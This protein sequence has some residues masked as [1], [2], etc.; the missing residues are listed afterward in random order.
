MC[1]VFVCGQDERVVSRQPAPGSCPYCGGMIQAVD[2]DSNWN[3]C[4]LPLY[5]KTK[6]RHYCTMCAR[7]LMVQGK[8]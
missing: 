8:T 7:K 5:H 6:R 3:F 2:V 1:L 4:F